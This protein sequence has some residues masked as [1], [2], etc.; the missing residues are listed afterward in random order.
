MVFPENSYSIF[1]S[2]LI[3]G[4]AK[5]YSDKIRFAIGFGMIPAKKMTFNKKIFASNGKPHY[6]SF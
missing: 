1:S 2:M 4:G 6:V 5:N 3:H